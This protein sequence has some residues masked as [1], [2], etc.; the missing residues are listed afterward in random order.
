MFDN[1]QLASLILLGALL[2]WGLTR[3][4]VRKSTL[5]LLHAFASPKVL[6]PFLLYGLWLIGLHW[7]SWQ[8]GLWNTKLIGESVFWTGLSGFAL[9]TLAVTDAGK[10]DNFFRKRAVDTVNFGSL[11]EFFLNIKSFSLLGELLF[12]PI[13][14]LLACVRVL[15]FRDDEYANIRKPLDRML[16][17]VALSLASYTLVSTCPPSSHQPAIILP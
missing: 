4:S 12:Q 1:R 10:R 13:I 8:T 14:V 16:L 6:I 5:S 11:F 15:A 17:L 7:L 2:V 3:R 9:L